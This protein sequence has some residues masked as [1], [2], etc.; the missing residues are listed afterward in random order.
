[1]LHVDDSDIKP[2]FTAYTALTQIRVSLFPLF[3]KLQC[4]NEC[5]LHV[6]QMVILPK[7]NRIDCEAFKNNGRKLA[8]TVSNV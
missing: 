7:V 6:K 8:Q 5:C 1:M 4:L 3:R 2:N